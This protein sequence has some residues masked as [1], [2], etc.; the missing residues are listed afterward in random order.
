MRQILQHVIAN[1]TIVRSALLFRAANERFPINKGFTMLNK[2][3][4]LHGSLAA[5]PVHQR[6]RNNI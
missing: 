5:G 6:K 2:L 1:A 3:H 4:T